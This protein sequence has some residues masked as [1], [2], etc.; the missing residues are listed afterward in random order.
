MTF[1]VAARNLIR[2]AV[3]LAFYGAAIV[4]FSLRGPTSNCASLALNASV[5]E[6]CLV[7]CHRGVGHLREL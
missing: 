2:R 7:D 4:I 1:C 5:A 6:I 3:A